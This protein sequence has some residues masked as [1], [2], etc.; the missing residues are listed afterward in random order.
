MQ[1]ENKNEQE[2]FFEGQRAGRLHLAAGLN[3][4]PNSTAQYSEWERGRSTVEAQRA[5]EEMRQR[6]RKCRY[7]ATVC[8][9][10]GRGL[11]LDVA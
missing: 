10:G 8:D 3:P 4:H 11:C 7:T 2:A 1:Q 9:C 6:A 5:A